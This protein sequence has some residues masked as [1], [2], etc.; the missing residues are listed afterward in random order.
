[1]IY[2]VLVTD[3]INDVALKILQPVCEVDYKPVVTSEELKAIINEYDALMIR[4]VKDHK[5]IVAAAAGL[6]NSRAV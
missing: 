2:R 3:R 5:G 6:S 4:S 1:M